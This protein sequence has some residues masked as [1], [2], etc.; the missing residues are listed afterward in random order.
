MSGGGQMSA[1]SFGP[2][3]GGDINLQAG[4]GVHISGKGETSGNASGIY[5][6]AMSESQDAGDGGRI[7]LKTR[8][9]SLNSGGRISTSS[10]GSGKAGEIH[11]NVANLE[12]TAEAVVSSESHAGENG[13]DAG[14]IT[15]D[16][17]DS[18]K[19]SDTGALSTQ[20]NGAGGGKIFLNA[21]GKL[22]LLGGSVTS[23][24]AIGEGNG[25]DVTS[26]SQFVILNHGN[27]TANADIGDGGA[28]FIVTENFLKSSDAKVTATSRRGNDGTVKI[29]APDTD[30]SSDLAVLPEGYMDA[31]RWMKNP[32][33]P[34]SKENLS[35][36]FIKGR[37]AVSTVFDDWEPAPLSWPAYSGLRNHS[38]EKYEPDAEFQQNIKN[39][40]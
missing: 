31:T 5:A 39:G 10:E 25:G 14:T 1:A 29:E 32:C 19:L 3:K 40:F 30:I 38:D 12:V 35:R 33:A 20:A 36:F 15:V 22:Y 28:I 21:G 8:E 6:S 34:L 18:V 16:A 11:L 26:Q 7:E 23:S 17:E 27:I 24:V 9:L 4:D 2:G 37:D 13:G